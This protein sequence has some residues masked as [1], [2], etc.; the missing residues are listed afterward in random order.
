MHAGVS[1]HPLTVWAACDR[2]QAGRHLDCAF[3]LQA[4]LVS[5]LRSCTGRHATPYGQGHAL[6][7]LCACLHG[8]TVASMHALAGLWRWLPATASSP[9]Y[10]LDALAPPCPF[11][12]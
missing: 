5:D 4:E 3:L 12:R 9:L 2:A 6:A 7:A 11:L 1:A 8:C 10:V